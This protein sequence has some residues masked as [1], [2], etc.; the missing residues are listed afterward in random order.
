MAAPDLITQTYL[1]SM[2]ADM[3]LTPN[4]TAMLP[5]LTT[6]ASRS[7]RVYCKR[8]F[9]RSIIDELYT[10]KDPNTLVLNQYPVNDVIAVLSNPTQVVS[11]TNSDNVTNQRAWFKLAM[12][13]SYDAGQVITGLTLSTTA[14]GVISTTTIPFTPN[15]TIA[16]LATAINAAGNAWAAVALSSY[17]AWAVAEIRQVQ[18][19]LS[20]FGQVTNGLSIHTQPMSFNLRQD[21]GILDISAPPDDP[22]S[23]PRWGSYMAADYGDQTLVG[24]T[25]GVRVI[26]DQ[27]FDTIPED[28]QQCTVETVQAMLSRLD[29]DPSLVSE[30][31]GVYQWTAAARVPAIPESAKDRLEPWVNR[32]G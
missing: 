19:N 13:G 17:G 11:I 12:T 29:T 22:F 6:S 24:A 15:M 5:F 18:G 7:I 2:L 20:G 30:N 25:N 4:Q 14:S 27:G 8:T 23:S 31:D 1:G 9:T 10:L 16:Q 21:S 26:Y 28:V 3:G 32:R